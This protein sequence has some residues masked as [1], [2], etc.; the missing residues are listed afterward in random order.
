[1]I[2][3][4]NRGRYDNAQRIEEEFTHIADRIGTL[5]GQIFDQDGNVIE[6]SPVSQRLQ[7]TYHNDLWIQNGNTQG[8]S[9]LPFAVDLHHAYVIMNGFTGV[10]AAGGC[11]LKFASPSMLEANR[12]N[13]SGDATVDYIVVY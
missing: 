8:F 3:L 1:M 4:R 5:L 6:D 11:R 9:I 12:D 10:T 2:G 13:S 7:N